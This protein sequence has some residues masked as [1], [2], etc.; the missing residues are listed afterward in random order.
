MNG[1]SFGDKVL[2]RTADELIEVFGPYGKIYRIGGD[3]FC[4][5]LTKNPENA[6]NLIGKYNGKTAAVTI[7]GTPLP[8]VSTGYAE[9]DPEKDTVESVIARAD[10]YMYRHKENK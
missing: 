4:A 10:K 6:E 1:H 3:E 8:T 9:F 7:D 2:R 5:V